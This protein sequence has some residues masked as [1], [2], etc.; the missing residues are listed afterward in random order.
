[1]TLAVDVPCIGHERADSDRSDTVSE[2][3]AACEDDGRTRGRGKRGQP[4]RAA[5]SELDV[6]LAIDELE[7]AHA[8]YLA[9]ECSTFPSERADT[10]KAA[11][12][13]VELAMRFCSSVTKRP[14]R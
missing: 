7:Q 11:R 6:R 1:M 4:S 3:I 13:K 14:C 5:E 8:L 2:P 10:L 12:E 9:A